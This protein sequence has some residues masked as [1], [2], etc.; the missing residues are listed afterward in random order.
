SII[1]VTISLLFG[2]G[3]YLYAGSQPALQ[4]LTG[5]LIE[6]SLS[7]DNIFVFVLLFSYFKVPPAYQHRV[8]FWGILGALLMRGALI[9]A[10]AFLLSQFHWVIYVFGAFLIFAGI[11]MLFH[12]DE[13]VD[14]DRN[15]VVRM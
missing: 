1:W 5:Y 3:L 10:G 13:E 14:A 2:A 6:K 11:R 4:F 7:V 15:I 12:Q 9:G 8:L